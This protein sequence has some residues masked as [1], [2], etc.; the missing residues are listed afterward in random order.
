M[1]TMRNKEHSLS[2]CADYVCMCTALKAF[3]LLHSLLGERD[4]ESASKH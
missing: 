3:V 2:G 4:G 1:K